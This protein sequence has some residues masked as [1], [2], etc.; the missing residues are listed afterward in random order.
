MKTRQL[1]LLTSA[2]L[3]LSACALS[4]QIVVVNPELSM[5]SST[6]TETS[7]RMSI[8]VSD[9]RSTNIIGQR[10]GIYKDTSHIRTDDDM[11]A[12]LRRKLSDAFVR[13][14]FSVMGSGEADIY[15]T[16][17][18]IKIQYMVIK[19]NVLNQIKID[20]EL[21]GICQK[22]NQQFRRKYQVSRTKDIVKTPSMEKNE[23]LVNE[24]MAIALG[25]LLADKAL[26][27]FINS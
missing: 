4:P 20:I 18:T 27:D 21:Q 13:M 3:V 15:L 26:L 25:N 23:E 22:N 24:A 2:L 17:N 16:V 11:T 1:L 7:L 9:P 14:G 12:T 19:D 8:D 5:E 6:M 10:G